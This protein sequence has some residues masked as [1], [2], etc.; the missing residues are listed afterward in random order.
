[1][2]IFNVEQIQVRISFNPAMMR[3]QAKSRRRFAPAICLLPYSAPIKPPMIAAGAKTKI[4]LGSAPTL[5]TLHNNLAF[6][7]A[8]MNTADSPDDWRVSARP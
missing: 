6:E 8:R 3:T 1:L 4:E 2:V 7:L 5:E